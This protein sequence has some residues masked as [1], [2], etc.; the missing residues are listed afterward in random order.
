MKQ[1]QQLMALT[2]FLSLG[3]RFEVVINLD[4]FNEVVLPSVNNIKQGVFP[5][6]PRAW[7]YRVG[8]LADRAYLREAGRLVSM[9]DRRRQVARIFSWIPLRYSITSNVFW[10]RLDLGMWRRLERR[11]AEATQQ[12]L[13]NAQTDQRSTNYAAMG[14]QRTYPSLQAQYADLAAYWKQC[15]VLLHNLAKANSF[16]YF[17]FLQPNQYVAGSKVFTEEERTNALAKDHPYKRAVEKGYPHLL[18][19]GFQMNQE[20]VPYTNLTM[21]FAD[22]TETLYVDTCC[23]FNEQ[24]YTLLAQTIGRVIARELADKAPLAQQ[25]AVSE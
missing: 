4:G 7:N 16:S 19:A 17:H 11:R 5:F 13:Q 21:L 23:H 20:G 15:S 14:P 10:E 18:Q 22:N 9:E 24:G 2:Y 1:P 6:Y 8:G 3:A 25:R 12:F